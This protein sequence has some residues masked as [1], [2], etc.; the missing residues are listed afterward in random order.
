MLLP[1]A[2]DDPG[3][4]DAIDIHMSGNARNGE[5][6][7]FQT[8]RPPGFLQMQFKSNKAWTAVNELEFVF[9]RLM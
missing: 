8:C 7:N 5:V 2:T 1:L 4:C 3:T 9:L 6:L